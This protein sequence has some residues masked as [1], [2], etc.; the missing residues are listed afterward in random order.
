M[1]VHKNIGLKKFPKQ[2]EML[3]NIVDVVFNYNTTDSIEGE[4]VRMDREEPFVTLFK[5]K[6]GRI[7]NATECQYQLRIIQQKENH[8]KD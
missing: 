8:G 1:G 4:I 2:D 5:L 7:V 6:D 3:N